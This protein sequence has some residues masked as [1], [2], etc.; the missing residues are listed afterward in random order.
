MNN[1]KDRVRSSEKINFM[2][3]FAVDKGQFGKLSFGRLLDLVIP[4]DWQWFKSI[5]TEILELS[6]EIINTMQEEGGNFL[7]ILLSVVSERYID[8]LIDKFFELIGVDV[9]EYI[10]GLKV[11]FNILFCSRMI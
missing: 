1:N 10:N 4:D 3:D 2:G 11:F 5:I 9:G 6:V 8:I 7:D